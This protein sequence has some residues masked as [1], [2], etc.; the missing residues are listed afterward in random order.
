VP[1]SA[2][3]PRGALASAGGADFEAPG[4]ADWAVKALEPLGQAPA[5]HH[6][7]LLGEL[8][9][10]SGGEI[11]RLMVLMP[12]GSAKSTYASVL[13]PAW[14]FTQHP[15][16]SVIAASHTRGFAEDLGR[17]VRNLVAENGSSLGYG[18]LADSRSAA[19]WETSTLGRYFATGVRGAL[20]GRRADL[21]IIDDP[22]R[23]LDEAESA[24]ARDRLWEWYRNTLLTRL[25]PKAAVLLVMTRWHE[26]DL[27]G[28][29]LEAQPAE[30][31]CLRLPALAEADDPLD[32]PVGAV[33]WPEWEDAAALARKR[34]GVGERTWAA[35]FQQS[36]RTVQGSVFK[37]AAIRT[38]SP[39]LPE[40]TKVV[41]AWDLAA[42]EAVGGSD[43]DWSVGL[44][45]AREAG[46][47]TVVLDVV[48]LRGSSWD[49][50]QAIRASAELDGAQ[51]L[52]GLPQ[53][54]GQAGK[55]QASYL[56]AGLAGYR[57][58]IS[59]ETGAKTTR[60]MPVAS[61][62]EAGNLAILPGLWNGAFIAELRDFPGGGK[63]DQVD[64]L[65]RAFGMLVQTAPPARRLPLSFMC[66]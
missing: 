22:I 58:D 16:T 3:E 18:L 44:K 34:A 19:R 42:T 49:V 30:W 51:V 55:A 4:L 32:R 63:D 36:P 24:A 39:P 45:L 56:A 11:D 5:R 35:Q 27:A 46:G 7:H 60:A 14:W 29:L 9:R 59:P 13:F 6:L 43:P 38:L 10:L 33:L 31:T 66:R 62:I 37:T 57:L 54:P 15:K 52:V 1:R 23:S 20:V 26:D 25:K 50:E 61:Q 12:P 41:R 17:Q 48:R 40:F 65:S 21:A 64:A 8:K 28:R 47:R 2:A 53:D